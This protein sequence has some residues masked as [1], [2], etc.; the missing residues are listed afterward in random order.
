MV[1]LGLT[2]YY[3]LRLNSPARALLVVL[4]ENL[5]NSSLNFNALLNSKFVESYWPSEKVK[6]LDSYILSLIHYVDHSMS[7]WLKFN[8]GDAIP[9]VTESEISKLGLS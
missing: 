1:L 4:K 3:F 2:M 8:S 9:I 5:V 7:L 6:D